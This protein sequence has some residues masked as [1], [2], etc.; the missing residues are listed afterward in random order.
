MRNCEHE[1]VDCECERVTVNMNDVALGFCRR[2]T[3]TCDDITQ[4]VGQG[5]GL[6]NRHG[7]KMLV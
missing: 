2:G 5:L 7:P 4:G 1:R 3:L 6:H